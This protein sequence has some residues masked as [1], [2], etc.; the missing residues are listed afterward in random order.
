M[1]P[2][3]NIFVGEGRHFVINNK[4]CVLPIGIWWVHHNWQ[5]GINCVLFGPVY[6]ISTFWG[7]GW[8]SYII[9]ALFG[10]HCPQPVC[11]SCAGSKAHLTGI[12][13]QLMLNLIHFHA[14][15]LHWRLCR[16]PATEREYELTSQTPGLC[17][18]HENISSESFVILFLH[19][20]HTVRTTTLFPQCPWFLNTE[21]PAAAKEELLFV[22]T[23]R[24]Y[25]CWGWIN[26]SRQCIWF[27][28]WQ[29][30]HI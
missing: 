16:D 7:K 3:Q 18:K 21:H 12:E 11:V 30:A 8:A 15:F 1:Q 27:V 29:K 24:S 2:N 23:A 13:V 19:A 6:S 5:Q 20:V 25:Q 22:W 4:E 28:Q 10:L 17:H 9:F 26:L 14:Q